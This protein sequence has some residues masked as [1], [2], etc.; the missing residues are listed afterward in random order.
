MRYYLD[1]N[2]LIFSL[3]G[4]GKSDLSS[5]TLDI[6]ADYSTVKLT[7]TVCIHELIHLCQIGKITIGKKK[8][9]VN[10]DSILDIVRDFDVS[11][12]TV[13]ERHLEKMTILPFHGDHRDPNDRLII[14]Q[15]ISDRIPLISS[16]GNFSDYTKDGLEFIYNER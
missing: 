5:D 15:A 1:T 2:I 9:L 13:T 11:I 14:A 12:V 16:D 10:S 7:S 6:L 8:L 3:F 4:S